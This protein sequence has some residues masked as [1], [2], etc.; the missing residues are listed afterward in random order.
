MNASLPHNQ[1]N[2]GPNM[3]GEKSSQGK[4]QE[5]VP[6]VG[7]TEEFISIKLR[8]ENSFKP[9]LRGSL[10]KGKYKISISGSEGTFKC[11][12]NHYIC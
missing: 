3:L 12:L 10:F 1:S 8:S 11:D 9:A 7:S 5:G 2:S 4:I 6:N